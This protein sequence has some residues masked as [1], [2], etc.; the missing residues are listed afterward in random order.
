MNWLAAPTPTTRGPA[1][2]AATL[3]LCGPVGLV[4]NG[5][6]PIEP[7]LGAKALALLTYLVLEPGPHSRAKL[8]ALL[9]GEYPNE[10]ARASLRQTLRHLRD[11]LG[12]ILVVDRTSVDLATGGIDCDIT[13][14]LGRGESAEA[15]NGRPPDKTAL[16]A[17]LAIDVPRFLADLPIRN[18][19]GFE[20]WASLTRTRLVR[21][22][23]RLV[24]V[25]A[26]DALAQGRWRDAIRL[27]DQ[28]ASLAPLEEE[29]V[30]ALMEA[31][32]LAGDLTSALAAYADHATRL[33]AEVHR[34]PGRTL[35][36][37]A[38]RIRRQSQTHRQAPSPRLSN[39][40]HEAVSFRGN[41]IGRGVEWDELRRSWESIRDGTA[42]VMLIEGAPGIGKTR[43]ADDFLR[44]VATQGGTVLRGAAYDAHAGAPFSAVIG[45]LRSGLGA[46]GLAGTD[47]D[48][49][50]Q[51]ARLLPEL[52]Q[53]FSG[54]PD[55][56][57]GGQP[58][59]SL[60]LF[61]AVAQVLL[62]MA[63]ECPL[64]ILIDDL[65]W[66][67]ADS[68]SLIQ[69]LIRRVAAAPVL[70]CITFTTG[71]IGR[72]APPARLLRALHL[73]GNATTVA[74]RPFADDDVWHLI[75][76][77]GRIESPTAGRRFA[78]RLHAVTGGNPFYV[79]ELLKTLFARRVL[80]VDQASG[81]WL[82]SSPTS[83]DATASLIA[84][85]VH[86]AIAERV[87]GLPEE[88]HV[89]LATI[90]VAGRRC[91]PDVVSHMHGISRLR[92]AALGDAL[93][94]RHLVVEENGGY[95]CAHA[96]LADV[97]RARLGPAHLRETHRALALALEVLLS[98]SASSDETVGDIA[99]HAEQGGDR[100]MAYRYALLAADA[101][102]RRSAFEE[103]FAW[104]DLATTCAKTA[105][106]T[107]IVG[108]H[109]ARILAEAGWREAPRVDCLSGHA[110][111]R[112]DLAD[113]DL[114]TASLG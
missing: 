36:D 72:D 95:R 29:P 65:Q 1:P 2:P 5:G 17:A 27:C 61:E 110:A 112:V 96:V 90:A 22:Y 92:A 6:V 68:C 34:A 26:R 75:R 31:L 105:E 83:R 94:E 79:I 97:V 37:L 78:A 28:W 103:A 56:S 59:E 50:A 4:T 80:T 69:F 113:L 24:A 55:P 114:P 41:L 84:P 74:L 45:A 60:R 49:L 20:E 81:A 23:L 15:N 46:P 71:V 82:V 64:T 48:S 70:W 30:A 106:E 25:A 100:A 9:W 53:T 91:P 102:G 111:A 76:E 38:A 104:L 99:R 52:R 7:A 101:C 85:N 98:S 93:V 42:R 66:C 107:Q 40:W 109:A 8:T 89:V 16:A 32:F 35:V 14:F 19:S 87:D 58:V 33:A 39:G 21:R 62:A 43:L 88:L 10:K 3:R 51:V 57:A 77:L 63:E 67:D 12:D 11:V 13:E 73:A 54:L 18:S 44:W 86:D 108:R 47:P